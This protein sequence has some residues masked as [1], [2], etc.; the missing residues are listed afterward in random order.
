MKG[1]S[2]ILTITNRIALVM[3]LMLLAM[4]S[5]AQIIMSG[6]V[7]N[8]K[9]TNMLGAYITVDDTNIATLTDF[10]GKFTLTIPDKYANSTV[11]VNY[12]DCAAQPRRAEH[13]RYGGLHTKAYPETYGRAYCIERNRLRQNPP[14][15][16]LRIG[17]GVQFRTGISRHSAQRPSGFLLH[18]WCVVRRAG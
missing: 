2:K 8:E 6:T 14:D 17:R 3:L 12:A 15:K 16:S 5:Q 1:M 18:T 10:D 4:A 7:K 13:R 9:G 11:T